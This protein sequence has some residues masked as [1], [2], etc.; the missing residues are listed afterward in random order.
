MRNA[1]ILIWAAAPLLWACSKVEPADGAEH[2]ALR[3][4]LIP[5]GTTHEFWKSIHAGGARAQQELGDVQ[6]IWRG[7]ERED[8]REQQVSLVQN[9]VSARV[10]AI[11]LAPMDQ[12]ALLPAVRS[13]TQA[14][15]PV[16]IVDSGLAG[17]AGTD[18]VS[19][20]ATDNGRGG[21]LGAQRLIE[22]LGGRGKVLLLR[23]MEGSE[24]T[25]QREQGFVDTVSQ[26]A[27][28]ELVDPRRYAGASRA[29]AQ[30]AA[31][32]LLA[33]YSDVH[34]V[35][36]PNESSTFGMLLALRSRG[37]AGKVRFVGFDA[38]AGLVTAL[39]A[40]ELD[41]LVIQD[42]VKMGY[43]GVKTAVEAACGRP[44]EQR[45]DTGVAVATRENMQQPE[46]AA[47]LHPDLSV[48][49]RR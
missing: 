30:D 5:K 4:A 44:V 38:S 29:S 13:A 2:A 33:T 24:S 20:V 49:D 9:F 16:V 48:L 10:D 7:P 22:V 11:V 19:Y 21:A 34:G 8:D 32:N 23:Y 42:P 18:Y 36:C 6:V 31:E 25:M 27:G 47:L 1:R 17:A 45:V 3:I 28:I 26:A 14:G 40:G 43:L 46:V 37:L 39:S 35:F 41:G 15:I 12:N